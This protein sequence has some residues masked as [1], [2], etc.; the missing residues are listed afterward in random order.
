[1]GIFFCLDKPDGCRLDAMRVA[2]KRHQLLQ[3]AQRFTAELG[4]KVQCLYI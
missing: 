3:R 1:M 2:E 4:S